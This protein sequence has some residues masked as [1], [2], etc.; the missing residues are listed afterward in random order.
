LVSLT[1][2]RDELPVPLALRLYVPEQWASDARRRKKA[3]IPDDVAFRPKWRI[4]LDEIDRIIEAEVQFGDV[5]ADAGYGSCG[6]FRAE[7]SRRGLLWTVGV[8]STQKAYSAAVE[9]VLPP[10]KRAGVRGH[11]REVPTEAGRS[12]AEL[13]AECKPSAVRTVTWRKGTKGPLSGRFARLRVRPAD[14]PRKGPENYR[15]PGDE[16]WLVAEFRADETRYYFSN[17]PS[18]APFK[19]LVS[20]IKARWSCE[21][22]HQQMKEEL[23]LD[24]FEG[25]SWHGLHHHAVLCMIAYAFLQHLRLNANKS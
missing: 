1:L 7:L 20:A 6:E 25:R 5:L 2:A 4:A 3:R 17:L 10:R 23:G 18:D 15:L 24:H 16:I 11:V 19:R 22:M 21:Q 9:M 14:G 13:L 8:P 12:V